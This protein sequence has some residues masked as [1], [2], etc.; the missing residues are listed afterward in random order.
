MSTRYPNCEKAGLY[1]QIF[2]LGIKG[3]FNDF[4]DAA[5]VEAYLAKLADGRQMAEKPNSSDSQYS[6]E[7][8]CS[9]SPELGE[10]AFKVNDF[11]YGGDTPDQG[12]H[13]NAD[14]AADAAN[15]ILAEKLQ[16]APV[17][18]GTCASGEFN[19][20]DPYGRQNKALGHEDT[21]SA[22]LVCVT[23]LVED[24]ADAIVTDLLELM[25]KCGEHRRIE[26]LHKL[27]ERAKRLVE[28]G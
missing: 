27:A 17:V 18:Y 13:M 9:S 24:S 26:A 20:S 19:F 12:W 23:P 21:H 3:Q 14:A 7:M 16:A 4:I 6:A 5:Y 11:L 25:D 22:R 8:T 2:E 10:L 15:R 1:T 28:R